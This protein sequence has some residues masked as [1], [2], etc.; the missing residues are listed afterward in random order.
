[1]LISSQ[2]SEVPTVERL[3]NIWAARYLPDLSVLPIG[4]NPLVRNELRAASSENGRTQAAEKLSKEIVKQK[5]SLAAIRTKDLLAQHEALDLIEAGRL[6]KCASHVY[7]KLL[8]V[9]QESSALVAMSSKGRL[10][11]TFGDTSLAAW[12]IPK[13]DQLAQVLEPLLLE[14]QEQYLLSKDWRSLGF[15]TTQINFSN[16]LLLEQLTPAEQVLIKPYFKFLEEQVAL[17]WQR[18]C[19]A[20]A[21]H[22]STSPTFTLV[23]QTLPK[24]TEISTAVYHRLCTAFPRHYGRRGG[25]N[26]PQVKHSCLRDFDMFQA[27][28]WLCI[29]ENNLKFVEQELVAMCIM[30]FENLNIS[31][32]MTAT[33]NQFLMDETLNHLDS[34][35]ETLV[36]PYMHGMIRAFPDT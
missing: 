10:W 25:L 4:N 32:K 16:A 24:V 2:L 1:M 22:D 35:Q 9:Y 21:K 23:E 8:E 28:L 19:A 5:C 11:E 17:P 15:I 20:G 12:G 27:Y 31:W 34:D 7:L 36:T 14:L 33:A 6:A 30:V 26:N 18:V 13:I 3:I 29:L